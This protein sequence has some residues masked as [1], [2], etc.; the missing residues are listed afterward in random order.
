[1]A[2]IW[3]AAGPVIKFTLGG[4]GPIQFLAYRFA[5]SAIV[6]IFYFTIFG[7]NLSKVR[8]NLKWI[9]AYGLFAFSFALGALF[10]GLEKTTVLDLALIATINPLLITAGGAIIFKD[11][12]TKREK[13]GISIVLAGA[14]LNS[15]APIFL[16][17][18]G[19]RFTGNIYIFAF[20]IF[21]TSA[22]LLAKYIVRDKVDSITLTNLG[23]IVA[24]LTII[25]F[26]FLTEGVSNVIYS[27]TN[28]QLQYHLGVWYMALLSG[29]LAYFL[30]VRGQKSIEVSEAA[31]FAYLQPIFSI[32]LAVFW[33]EE[34]ITTTFVIGAI[35]ITIGVIIAEYKKRNV[36]TKISNV[37]SS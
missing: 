31:L 21:D 2:A 33:L 10:T 29:T 26:A 30:Y 19:V 5:I 16:N 7:I 12:I 32:P 25:P 3:G 20:L 1:V 28:L 34:S 15:V 11:H 23:F 22:I 37:K 14:L 17:G 9:I 35:L 6:S 13:V 27:V 4:I 24:A 8:K 18:M 36:K